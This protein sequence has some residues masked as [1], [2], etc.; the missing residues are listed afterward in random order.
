MACKAY[1]D[2]AKD[3][4]GV[5]Y[6]EILA[7]KSAHAAFDK[8]GSYLGV[9]LRHIQLDEETWSVDI[10]AMERAISRNTIMVILFRLFLS[11][12]FFFLFLCYVQVW[13]CKK[14]VTK[15]LTYMFICRREY[16]RARESRLQRI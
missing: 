4:R 15:G 10:K 14:K 3:V 2:Y 11:V 12:V 8:A 9:R 7:P 16:L 6:P 1:R 5:K 13:V